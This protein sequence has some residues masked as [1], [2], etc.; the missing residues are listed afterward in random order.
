MM[1]LSRSIAMWDVHDPGEVSP[2][3]NP[4]DERT[5]EEN[6]AIELRLDLQQLAQTLDEEM[7]PG[8]PVKLPE[9]GCCNDMCA[10][11]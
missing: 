5:E 10:I 8:T 11:L 6:E 9:R 2:P 1:P 7:E 3:Q 4:A